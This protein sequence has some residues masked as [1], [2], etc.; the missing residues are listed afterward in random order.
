MGHLTL[1]CRLGLASRRSIAGSLLGMLLALGAAEARAMQQPGPRAAAVEVGLLLRQLDGEKRVLMV[2]AHPDDEDTSMLAAL[3]LGEGVRTAYLSLTR[4]EGGQNLIGP[5]LDEGLGL[6]RTGEL[7]SARSLDG[8]E[9]YFS[10]AFDFGFSK[11]AE[12]T[13]GHWP[14]DELTRDIVWVIRN[15]RPHVIIS[16]FSGTPQ[17]G[18][19]QHQAAGIVTRAAFDAAGDPERFPDQLT[20]GMDTWA[21]GK[22]YLLR[23]GAAAAN[24]TVLVQ[25]GQLDPLMGRSF[26]Q[27]AMESRSRHSSQDMGAAQDPGPRTSGAL[28]LESRVPG[29]AE[30]EATGLFAGIDTTLVGIARAALAPDGEGL[31]TAMESYRSEL[32]RAADLLHPID[33]ERAVPALSGALVALA[34]ARTLAES[35]PDGPGRSELLAVLKAREVGATRAL[36]A[37]SGVV[38]D[39]RADRSVVVPGAE[40][41][42]EVIVWNG[43]GRVVQVDE[44]SLHLPDGW[45]M[46]PS[47]DFSAAA[48]AAGELVRWSFRVRVPDSARI[49]RPYFMEEDREGSLYRW[50]DRWPADPRVVG[51]SGNPPLFT[52]WLALRVDDG[53]PLQFEGSASHVDVDKASGE[54]RGPVFVLPALS[55]AVDPGIL[56]W[57]LGSSEER[58]VTVRMANLDRT[59]RMGQVQLM[60]PE[61][62]EVIPSA[63]S[64]AAIPGGGEGTVTFHIRPVGAEEG[65]GS[66]RAVVTSEGRTYDESVVLVDYPHID[67]APWFRDAELRVSRFPVRVAEGLRVG[68][69]MGPGDGGMQALRDLG[70]EVESLGPEAFRS[71][72]LDRFDALVLGVRTYETRTDL[73]AA[74]ARILDFARSGGTVVV[75]YNKYEYPEGGFA[76]Y[77]LE[78]ARPHDRV[79]DPI[80]EVAFLLPDHRALTSPN[81]LDSADFDGWVQE[82]GLYFL[83]DWDERYVPLVGMSDPGEPM[84]AG[85]LVV[86]PVGAGV[87]VYTG[88]ALFRQ[89]PAGVPGAYRLLAN[90]V[91]LRGSDL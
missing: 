13:F 36:L 15:F 60:A 68:Y 3:A 16:I 5:E 6:I 46:T 73:I 55:V 35:A 88:L 44:V 48:V 47:G 26:H 30:D 25:T 81:R 72:S 52:G 91:S 87:Y 54:F 64:F 90:L 78:M 82:R 29:V 8:A 17:D 37:A 71:T 34:E 22:L 18:H 10:R 20:S 14:E 33:P 2:G 84:N 67:P 49:S 85:S 32:A 7:M 59:S 51:G 58:E 77:P 12:E 45:E 31:A 86:A 9:Q 42:A 62:W 19:G 80:A 28:L 4:G 83:S 79:T 65:I 74:N 66:F 38:I 21:P 53:A 23:R 41:D 24:A 61:G 27:V 57:P 75:Q 39:V 11:S 70:V 63:Q 69:I 56:A 50:P 1:V 43:G 89:F 76:P 40:F